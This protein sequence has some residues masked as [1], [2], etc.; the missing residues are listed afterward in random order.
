LNAHRKAPYGSTPGQELARGMP[1]G[2]G[3]FAFDVESLINHD[4]I[5]LSRQCES[6]KNQMK[7]MGQNLKQFVQERF[8]LQ[9]I[10][11]D[12]ARREASKQGVSI[13]LDQGKVRGL[14]FMAKELDLS[15][16][17]LLLEIV[18]SGLDEVIEAWAAQHGDKAGEA[19]R[20][21]ADL[22]SIQAEDL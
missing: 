15:R 13:R 10:N 2:E 14:D 7:N 22:M 19:Y 9:V 12:E 11:E 4:M 3:V 8:Q 5:H 1:P 18:N 21:V 17:A 16:Q 20:K 6:L